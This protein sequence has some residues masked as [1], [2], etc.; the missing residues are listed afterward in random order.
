MKFLDML[1]TSANN[2]WKRKFRSIL[3]IMG[4]VIGVA[5]IV[6][7]VSLGLGLS[8]SMMEQYASYGSITEIRVSMPYGSTPGELAGL[9]DS[10][11]ERFK[12]IEHVESVYPSLEL[13][14]LSTF[15]GY[16][17]NVSLRGLPVEALKGLGFES[18]EGSLPTEDMD[19]LQFFYG[20]EV[21]MNYSNGSGNEYWYTGELPDIDFMNGPMFTVFDLDAYALSKS[22]DSKTAPPKKFLIP[23]CGIQKADD[24][25]ESGSWY[26]YCD[27]DK[28]TVKLKQVFK[29]KPIPG[30]PLTKKGK[31]YPEIYYNTIFVNVDDL[32][33]VLT[34]ENIIKG[35]GYET[36]S[37]GEWVKSAQ[38][39]MQSVQF[40][41]GGIGAVSLFVAAIG[42]TNTMMMS[43]YERTKEIGVMKVLGCS[44]ENIRMLFILEAAMIGFVGG[45]A[46][47]GLSYAVSR[48]I[49]YVSQGSDIM[50]Y[51]ETI[52]NISRIPL[53]LAGLSVIFAIIISMIAGFVPSQKAMR[54]S[55]LAAIRNE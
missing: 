51:G 1:Q 48:I 21:A 22:A 23:T 26:V 3:T 24:K 12:D 17:G 13:A 8:N 32:D 54:L 55:P 35:M 5:S 7:M 38:Q 31:P 33:N 15:G 30:Q 37:N 44:L 16:S 53:W 45:L 29:K 40:V 11:V 9:D 6:I 42:I 34:V 19:D 25:V 28:L 18:I 36:Y 46:G 43:I 41:L 2:L 4:V 10:M 52:G 47:V 50:G 39:S 49:N 27:I 20:K 14:V